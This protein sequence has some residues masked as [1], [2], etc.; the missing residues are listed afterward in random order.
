MMSN[1][2]YMIVYVQLISA[3]FEQMQR[4]AYVDSYEKY[5]LQICYARSLFEVKLA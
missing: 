4:V 1:A 3:V 2:N 5:I